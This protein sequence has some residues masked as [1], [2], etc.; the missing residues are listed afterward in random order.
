MSKF[1]TMTAAAVLMIAASAAGAQEA[2]RIGTSSVGSVFYTIAIG[3]GEIVQKH[4]GLNT[5]VE[6]VGGSSANMRGLQ[7]AKIEFA[8]GNAFASFTAFHGS[9]NF[10]K[11]IDVRLVIQGQPSSR[12]LWARK[13]EG[14]KSP[15]DLVGKTV[16]GKRR[17]LPEME[18][19]LNAYIK[20]FNLPKD[21]IKIV[22]TTNTPQAVKLIQGGSVAAAMMPFSPRSPQIQKP[23]NDGFLD[24]IYL[25]KSDRDAMLGL[26]PKTFWANTMKVGT[27]K[28]QTQPLHLFSLNTYFMT[29]ARVADDAVYRVTKALLENNKEFTTYHRLARLWTAERAVRNVALPFHDGAIRYFKEKGLWNASLE[30]TQKALLKR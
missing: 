22:A 11:P 17:A 13:G 30:A 2:V 21:R 5:T 9:H 3:A 10:K 19:V 8:L 23:L 28:G 4:S 15:K 24:F 27:F 7:A 25:A 29:H 26:L 12:Y 18:L 6:P 20:H 1:H 16:I 14:I